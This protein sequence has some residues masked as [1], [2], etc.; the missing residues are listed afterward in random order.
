MKAIDS[1]ERKVA[2]SGTTEKAKMTIH[3]DA[4]MFKNLLSSI[5]SEKE[6]TVVRELMANAFDAHVE[7]GCP[8]RE[9]EVHL[10]TAL[11]PT[12]IVR[13]YGV[14]MTH[15][16]IM[17]LYSAVGLSTKQGDNTQTGM[18]G[19]GSKSPMAIT[20]SFI[21]KA[22]DDTGVRQYM[23]VIPT[24]GHP[25]I[26][27]TFHTHDPEKTY[28]RGIEVIVP[29]DLTRR[30]AVLDGLATQHFCWFDKKVKFLGAIGEVKHRFY[31]S[32]NK[33][34]DGIY[35]ASP[36]KASSM[37]GSTSIKWNVYVRQGAAVYPLLETQIVGKIDAKISST[38]TTLCSNGR[39]LLIDL[40]IGTA[41]VT[42]AREAIQYDKQSV[43]NIVKVLSARFESFSARLTKTVGDAMDY[44]TATKRI[45][46]NL[47]HGQS[48][49]L[50]ANLTAASLLS[51]VD[52]I[53]VK[54]HKAW[55]DKLPDVPELDHEGKPTGRMVRPIYI[56]PSRTVRI[57]RNEFPE[58][59][60]LLHAGYFYHNN[61]T[62][63][64]NIGG[65]EHYL[66]FY[67][68][69]VIFVLPS[70]LRDWKD[71]IK[72]YLSETY[73]DQLLPEDASGAV[74][75]MIVRCAL[76]AVQDVA[77][78]LKKHGINDT[79][80]VVDDLPDVTPEEVRKRNF[81]K[82]SVYPFRGS[83]WLDDKVE[84]DYSKPA[85]YVARVGIGSEVYLIDSTVS[86]NSHGK[87]IQKCTNYEFAR[88]VNLALSSK[89]IDESWPIYRVTE[90]QATR[91]PGIAQSWVHLPTHVARQV[92]AAQSFDAVLTI[93]ASDLHD[94]YDRLT[95]RALD[96]LRG[97]SHAH[98]STSQQNA[99]IE[100][101]N[102]LCRD[103]PVV[104]LIAA[105]R[106]A[107]LTDKS[108]QGANDNALRNK[109]FTAVDHVD[110]NTVSKYND[111]VEDYKQRYKF[112]FKLF[113]DYG[114]W[115]IHVNAYLD[116]MQKVWHNKPQRVKVTDYPEL[117]TYRDQFRTKLASALDR[118]RQPSTVKTSSAVSAVS[119]T[120][121]AKNVA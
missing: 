58:G 83:S 16:F 121:G 20:D 115:G 96:S 48:N 70:H 107:R 38:I 110:H 11:D 21:V 26:N 72:R 85:Y 89:L 111:L 1:G 27:F 55:Y 87:R 30:G 116:G 120:I 64:A 35:L 90:N 119:A 43:D 24:D 66:N 4:R 42:M 108:Q 78:V 44:P 29:V 92:D 112:M 113:D 9:I 52:H 19:V 32:I 109:L 95:S 68:P 105:V 49:S 79:P 86:F 106:H 82:T 81:S 50:I 22:Y 51:L 31:T 80:V 100:L 8:D 37:A 54:N 117:F 71:V 63:H 7:A 61:R 28:E 76:K 57:A 14:G 59:K 18:F 40:P 10:P 91:I 67:W 118:I 65:N 73:K 39:H 93:N 75:M 94:T 56:R 12:L 2:I 15:D 60:V 69:S 84:P 46:A 77:A 5:Y 17:N 104:E 74:P 47:N 114:E 62:M 101:L 13:D 23:V 45:A 36:A 34:G 25:E 41:N 99:Y 102:R 3:A 98:I 97:A 6:K 53:I 103:D 33:V 88:L